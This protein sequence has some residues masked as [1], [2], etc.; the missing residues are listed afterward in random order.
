M[1]QIPFFLNY[2]IQIYLFS[3]IVMPFN[4]PKNV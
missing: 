2:I 3:T 1:F 4:T